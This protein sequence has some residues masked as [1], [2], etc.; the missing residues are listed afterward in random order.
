MDKYIDIDKETPSFIPEVWNE[1][2][3]DIY[4]LSCVINEPQIYQ[5]QLYGYYLLTKIDWFGSF[6]SL[7]DKKIYNLLLNCEG[8]YIVRDWMGV[9]FISPDFTYKKFI[10][11]RT[12]I[13]IY[14]CYIGT[15][16]SYILP[17]F[18]SEMKR[19]WNLIQT[20]EDKIMSETKPCEMIKNM[21]LMIRE[22]MVKT[23][24]L[25]MNVRDTHTMCAH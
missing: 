9:D 17:K 3:T 12:N 14:N 18:F 22:N 15:R 20:N 24:Q 11:I 10:N 25:L 7:I 23:G 2:D 13:K 21:D 19:H 1:I 5:N 16:N 6:N 8:F 4:R